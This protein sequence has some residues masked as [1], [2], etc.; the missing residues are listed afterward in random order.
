MHIP[1][2]KT[3]RD[4]EAAAVLRASGATWDTIGEVLG[5]HAFVLTRWA[6]V[7]R[8][9]WDQYLHQAHERLLERRDAD[10]RAKLRAL[11][12][13]ANSRIRRTTADHLLREHRARR[14]AEGP[15]DLRTDLAALLNHVEQISDEE[16]NEYLAEFI[17]TTRREPE[18]GS[19]P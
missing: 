12:R 3:R 8:E 10:D 5:R 16:L 19:A 18:L 11:L 13:H 1:S 14:A 4:M 6:R 9:D 15:P 17:A 2:E 7:Y